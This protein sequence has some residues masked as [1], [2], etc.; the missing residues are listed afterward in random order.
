M[1]QSKYPRNKLRIAPSGHYRGF[2]SMVSQYLAVCRRYASKFEQENAMPYMD[3]SR[4]VTGYHAKDD[5]DF[6]GNPWNNYFVQEPLK[7]NEI[8]WLECC[9]GS[10]DLSIVIGCPKSD[11]VVWKEI[12]D[13]YLI[14]QPHILDKV[15]KFA[16]KNFIGKVA[17]IHIRGTDSFY[18][19]TRVHLPVGFY[20]ELIAEKLQDYSKILI[21]TDS[22]EIVEILKSSFGDKIINYD[23]EKVTL[24]KYRHHLSYTSED[25]YKIGE[26]VLIESLLMAKCDLLIKGYSNVSIFSLVENPYINFHQADLKFQYPSLPPHMEEYYINDLEISNIDHYIEKSKI[27]EKKKHELQDQNKIDELNYLI[28]EYFHS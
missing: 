12:K 14:V 27:F 8:F 1:R 7:E 24:E 25:P 3:L 5:V 10:M 13:K 16:N 21:C 2:H 18:D 9:E 20:K 17:A 15:D 4:K 19:K 11:F 22:L 28:K 26:D 6:L 23:S